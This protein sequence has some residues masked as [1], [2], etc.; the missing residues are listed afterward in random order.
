MI[1]QLFTVSTMI[2]ALGMTPTQA[3]GELVS[4]KLISP[5]TDNALVPLLTL[6]VSQ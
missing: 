5:R 4:R 6:Q 3:Y 1:R 2:M